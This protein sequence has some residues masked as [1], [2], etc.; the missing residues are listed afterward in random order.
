MQNF[1]QFFTDYEKIISIIEFVVF[2]IF[3]IMLYR[4]TGNIKYLTEVVD[5]MKYRTA[6]YN[7][8][9]CT[10]KK[11]GEVK[12]VV[13]RCSQSF[14][15]L[16]PIYRLNKVT[17]ELEK[18]D[19]FI[20]IQEQIES[21]KEMALQSMLERFM[22]KLVDDTADY[23]AIKGDLDFLT[24][25]LDIAEEYREKFGLSD[26]A[27]TQDIFSHMKKYSEELK[28]ALDNAKTGGVPSEK[29]ETEPKS[30]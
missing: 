24:E 19:E 16:V 27:T 6:H 4:K 5:K 7:V 28:V 3:S 2:F 26:T 29:K 13:N 17:N 25:S 9:E 30:E 21:Y 8:T 15:K 11:T 10:D 1:I 14:D 23:T 12:T 22:P 18:T 20:D